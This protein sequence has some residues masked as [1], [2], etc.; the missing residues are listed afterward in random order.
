[1]TKFGPLFRELREA[2]EMSRATVL[3]YIGR[4]AP[5]LSRIESGSLS[6]SWEVASAMLDVLR[7]DEVTRG[8]LEKAWR[9]DSK[10]RP[11]PKY[12]NFSAALRGLL[13]RTDVLAS[14]VA[15]KLGMSQQVLHLWK[16]GTGLPSGE[17]LDRLAKILGAW[18]APG[19][20]VD[21]LRRMHTFDLLA[22]DPRLAHLDPRERRAIAARSVEVVRE[23]TS[24]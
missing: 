19:F 16:E 22:N 7:V 2:A 5:T 10:N 17:T 3:A 20:E 13:E 4:S 1:M 24:A 21:H 23:R 11:A 9:Y 12:P 14:E 18:G 8:R 6:P 15:A